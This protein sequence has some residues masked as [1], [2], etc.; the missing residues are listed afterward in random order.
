MRVFAVVSART[1]EALELFVRREDGERFIGKVRDDE[2]ELADRSYR[3][4]VTLPP[5]SGWSPE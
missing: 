3:L 4:I 2:P 5:R 1:D